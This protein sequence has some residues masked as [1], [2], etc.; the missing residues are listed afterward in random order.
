MGNGDPQGLPERE[1]GGSQLEQCCS[2]A[3]K[4]AAAGVLRITPD[5][6]TGEHGF[7]E[8][9]NTGK[10]ISPLPCSISE[11]TGDQHRYGLAPALPMTHR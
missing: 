1:P 9:C 4:M 10:I 7:L 11:H 2:R 3:G 8:D 6:G 5:R